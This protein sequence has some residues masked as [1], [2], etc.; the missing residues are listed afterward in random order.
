[1][2]I[3]QIGSSDR[4]GGAASISWLLKKELEKRGYKM[5]MFVDSKNSDDVDVFI[6][7]KMINKYFQ[8]LLSNDLDFSRTDWII[9]TKEFKEADIIH[10]HNIHTW[11]FN[12]KTLEKMSKLK[13]IVWTLHDMWAITPHCAHSYDC[14]LKDGFYQCKSL[15][16]Y[17]RIT[18]PNSKYLSWRKKNIYKNSKFNLVVPS[19]WLK[20]K[21]EQSILKD[22]EINLIY[23][24]IDQNIFKIYDKNEARVE[25]DLPLDKKIILFLSD[26]GKRNEFK[27]WN[28][29]EETIEKYKNNKDLLFLCIGGKE[30]KKDDKYSNLFYIS[31]ISNKEILAKYFSSSDIFLYPSLA[32]TFALV[33]AEAMACGIPVVTFETGGIPEIVKHLENGYVAK[34]KDEIDLIKGVDYILN[35]DE[36][37]LNNIKNQSRLRIVENFTVDKMVLEYDELYKKI[38]NQK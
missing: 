11:F 32:D 28:F 7:P 17:P 27:G 31:K 24:G 36:N 35:L 6:I 29:I 20:E 12:L 19:L 30:T 18:W 5:T 33:V 1:M 15:N 4:I 2:N 10:L 8:M 9:N 3:L 37:T 25:L 13:P 34:Y 26:G 23:N 16:S 38:L 21:V 14:D 22:R